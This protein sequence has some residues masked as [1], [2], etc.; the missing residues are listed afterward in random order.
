MAE[1]LLNFINGKFVAPRSGS[2][3]KNINPST[4]K[5]QNLVPDSDERDVLDAVNAARKAYPGWRDLHFSERAVYL[6]KIAAEIL[7]PE[8][9]KILAQADTNDM[10]CNRRDL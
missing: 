8:N 3:I 9:I 2:Y 7:K 1:K 10:V 4:D 5:V 6:K